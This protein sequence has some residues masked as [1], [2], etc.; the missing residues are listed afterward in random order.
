MSTPIKQLYFTPKEYLELEGHSPFKHEYQRGL[1]YA[2]AGGK[3][4]HVKITTNLGSLLSVHLFNSPCS[5][6]VADMKVRITT[7]DCYYY[8]DISVTCSET[9]LGNDDDNF[10]LAPKLI[11]EVLSKSTE[12]FDRTDKFSDYQQIL[13]LEE[14]VLVSQDKVQ[15][16]CYRKQEGEW[17]GHYYQ[18]GD[19]VEIVSIGFKCPIEQIYTKVLGFIGV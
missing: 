14:Y 1:V 6:Y 13:E 17:E 2:M 11:I 15:V 4:K 8:P 19:I 3:K 18:R 16:E 9:D 5:V 10:I 7:A 12:Q